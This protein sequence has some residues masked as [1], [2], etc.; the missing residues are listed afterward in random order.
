MLDNT[1]VVTWR[2]RS[3]YDLGHKSVDLILDQIGLVLRYG[4]Q[5]R[6]RQRE[7]GH[8]VLWIPKIVGFYGGL[9]EADVG[10]RKHRFEVDGHGKT[11]S[12]T[13]GPR[14]WTEAT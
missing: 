3:A 8:P 12:W 1:V 4:R 9:V 11:C 13:A 2:R 14:K 10:T 7:L 5:G 6:L